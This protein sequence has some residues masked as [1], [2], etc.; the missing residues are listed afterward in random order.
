MIY[1]MINNR[2]RI[3]VLWGWQYINSLT[4]QRL[5]YFVLPGQPVT[6]TFSCSAAPAGLQ[7][8]AAQ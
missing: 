6:P 4:H 3:P 5:G 1:D 7:E 2:L 8:A